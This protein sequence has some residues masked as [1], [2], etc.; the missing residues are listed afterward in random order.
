MP[1]Y[2]PTLDGF[3]EIAPSSNDWTAVRN[4]ATGAANESATTINVSSQK[5]SDGTFRINRG[6]LVFDTSTSGSV[7]SATVT[8]RPSSIDNGDDDGDDFIVLVAA[9]PAS[10]TAIANGDADQFGSV[11]LSDRIDISTMSSGQDVVFTLN[12]DGKNH[13]N[14]SGNTVF[15]IRE[16]HDMIDSAYAGSNNTKSRV[17][18]ES[19]EATNKPTLTVTEGSTPPAD[20]YHVI[21]N[22]GQ[23]NNFVNA[24]NP[25]DTVPDPTGL[26]ASDPDIF[27]LL[28][29]DTVAL[30]TEPLDHDD[31]ARIGDVGYLL[32]FAK[33]YKE[34]HLPA[35]FKILIVPSAVGATGFSNNRWNKG[36]DLYNTM[37]SRVNTAMATN[38][39][40]V[41]AAL[42]FHGGERDAANLVSQAQETTYCTD[43]VDDVRTD[44]GEPNLPIVFGGL[45]PYHVNAGTT[46]YAEVNAALAD[47]PNQRTYVGFA[48]PQS[49]TVIAHEAGVTNQTSDHFSAQG[50]RG[51]G[52]QDFTDTTTLALAGRYGDGFVQALANTGGGGGGDELC[53][54]IVVNTTTEQ[55]T[56]TQVTCP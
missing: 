50:M 23:S 33:W 11:E 30:A 34:N 28:Q 10:E 42:V 1:T 31:P 39:E 38:T 48:D 45:M 22:G 8:L 56:V 36:D 51:D 40:N 21:A 15:G 25:S 20:K 27:Q 26:D 37:V 13:I 52:P 6:L 16:G 12:A 53:Y 7:D 44:F 49:P 47:M 35:G 3:I 4:A 32:A 46:N 9:T 14:T 29:D 54:T 55:L 5:Q 19:S 2:N 41:L 43:F 17:K 24:E 18:F